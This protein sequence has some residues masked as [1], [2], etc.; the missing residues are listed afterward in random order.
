M[1]FKQIP[2]GDE[3]L[4]RV[5]ENVAHAFREIPGASEAKF[6]TTSAAQYRIVGDETCVFVDAHAAAVTVVLPA[7]SAGDAAPILKRTDSS[8]QVVT[9]QALDRKTIDGAASVTMAPLAALR[10]L[11]DGKSWWTVD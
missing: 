5:Q 8:K 4:D 6:V 10:L 7:A 3:N 11:F 1:P 2:T 9:V